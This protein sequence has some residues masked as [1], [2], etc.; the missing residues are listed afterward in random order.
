IRG[1]NS[2]GPL[3]DAEGRVVGVN[4]AGDDSLDYN[5]AIHRD[6]AQGVIEDLADGKR[7]ASIGINA[8]AWQSDD[9]SLAGIWV[10]S[11]E[12]GG[13]AD[14]AGVEPGDL[15]YKFGGVSVGT[16]GT[17]GQYCQV[18]DTQGVDATI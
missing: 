5:F 11:V 18:L 8:K 6:V 13:P 3:V 10:Q 4:Y 17:L 2:G 15:L 16:D 9:G 12:A 1:G 7:V 14:A